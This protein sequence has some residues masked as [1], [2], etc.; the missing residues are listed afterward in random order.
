[1]NILCTKEIRQ[2]KFS[3]GKKRNQDKTRKTLCTLKMRSTKMNFMKVSLQIGSLKVS[4]LK[5]NVTL[6]SLVLYYTMIKTT[7][8]KFTLR[9]NSKYTTRFKEQPGKTRKCR[10]KC[11][12]PTIF[13]R[14]KYTCCTSLSSK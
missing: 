14:A 11:R 9:F 1:M 6:N 4:R 5:V 10:C 13:S 8:T 2:S 7:R 3:L 12:W